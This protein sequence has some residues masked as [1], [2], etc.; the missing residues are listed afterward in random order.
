[1]TLNRGYRGATGTGITVYKGTVNEIPVGYVAFDVQKIKANA[2]AEQLG[3]SSKDSIHDAGASIVNAGKAYYTELG[4]TTDSGSNPP[5][6]TSGTAPDG[7][8]TF[9]HI[10]VQK[11]KIISLWLYICSNQTSI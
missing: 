8:V 5:T 7:T 10:L 9:G 2:S 1:M 6:H 11:H 3:W 4:G